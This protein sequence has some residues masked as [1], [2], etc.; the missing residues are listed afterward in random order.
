MPKKLRISH[1]DDSNISK[2]GEYLVIELAVPHEQ[3]GCKPVPVGVRGLIVATK[4][5]HKE[6]V[7]VFPSDYMPDEMCVWADGHVRVL[8]DL[9]IHKILGRMN[10]P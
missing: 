8:T 2:K 3:N 7:L 10:R 1:F 9:K 4:N 6:Y 5:N